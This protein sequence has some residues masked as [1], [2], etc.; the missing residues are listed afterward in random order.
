MQAGHY[1]DGEWRQAADNGTIDSID[2]A[3]GQVIGQGLLGTRALAV[4]A[5]DAA[6]RAFE[7]SE[8]SVDP[9]LRARVLSEFADRL[10]ARQ[11]ELARL[12]T[13]EN[14]KVL[15]QAR[16]EIAAG[17][18]EARYYSGLARNVFGRTTETG[19]ESCRCSPVKRPESRRSSSRGMPR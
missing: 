16:H 7:T 5:I 4:E 14:G 12:L 13:R 6:R 10:E 11:E 3:T 15:G 8:W 1:I 2:P 19:Q 17:F 9:R 18:G